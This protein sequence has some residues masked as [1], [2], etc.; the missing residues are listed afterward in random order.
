LRIV[1]PFSQPIR[2]AITVAGIVGVS[3]SNSRICTSTAS[4]AEPFA[5]RWY[6]GGRSL[7]SARLT[8]F[9]EMPRCRAIARIGISSARCRR[10]ISAQSSTRITLPS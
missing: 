7:A 1:I 9:F 5:G 10:R 4:T 6:F 3:R 8:V 2:S